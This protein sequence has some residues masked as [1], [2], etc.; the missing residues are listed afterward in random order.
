MGEGIE[1]RGFNVVMNVLFKFIFEFELM[2]L[3][4]ISFV[5]TRNI[6]IN[7]CRPQLAKY[8]EKVSKE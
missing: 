6:I 2:N 8:I 3:N 7:L 5:Y 1:A 4:I